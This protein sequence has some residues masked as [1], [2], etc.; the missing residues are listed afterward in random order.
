MNPHVQEIIRHGY[1]WLFLVALLER[2]G[3]PLLVTPVMIA[4]GA[5]AGLGDLSLSGIIL[6]TTVA[7][8]LGDSLWYELGRQRGASVL[9][10][11]CKVS[12]EP[13]SCV[14][15]SEDAFG[16]HTTSALISSKFVPGVGRLAPPVAGLSGMPRDRFLL[17]NGLGSL[18]WAAC[19]ALVGYIPA[20]KLPIGVLLAEAAGWALVGLVV[21]GIGKVVWKYVQRERF[22]RSLRVSRITVEDLKANLDR[23]ERPFIVDLRHMLEFVVDPRTVPTAVRISPDE[24]PVRNAE[25]PR[26][27]DIVLY[28]TCPSEATSAKVAMDLKKMGIIKVRPLLGGLKAWQDQGFPMDDFFPAEPAKASS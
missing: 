4:A 18:L 14:R 13:D 27:R 17:V 24:L 12:L 23:G 5:V 28:C 3:L 7:A 10:L 25:I 15:R 2:I 11:L 16:R 26:D 20:R 9:R 22:I 6:L 8:E 19:F 1:L 21:A